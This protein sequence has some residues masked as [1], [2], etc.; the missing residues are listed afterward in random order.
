VWLVAFKGNKRRKSFGA[1]MYLMKKMCLFLMV[2]PFATGAPSCARR[3]ATGAPSCARRKDS[4]SSNGEKDLFSVQQ[5]KITFADLALRFLVLVL[6]MDPRF[7]EIN[8]ASARP[9]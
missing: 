7:G 6:K 8:F 3:L 5:Q 2:F 9:S 1:K 4:P